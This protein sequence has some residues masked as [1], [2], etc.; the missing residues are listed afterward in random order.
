MDDFGHPQHFDQDPGEFSLPP[1]RPCNIEAEQSLLGAI[2]SNNDV[3]HEAADVVKIHHFYDPI[4]QFL[5]KLIGERITRHAIAD[6]RTLKPFID[7]EPGFAE[8][9][10][11]NYLIKL[12][13]AA[14]SVH[15]GKQYAQ[16]I[17]QLAIRRKLI[18]LY[19]E[20]A[21]SARS[22][23]VDTSAADLI[24]DAE[25][26]LYAIG[27]SGEGNIGFQS[28]VMS[29]TGAV[30]AARTAMERPTGLS[31]LSTGFI[32]IDRKL[33]GLQQADLVILAGRPGMGK[34]ALA[35]NIAYNVA[36][37]FS[38]HGDGE[39]SGGYVGMF[40]LEMP[41]SQLAARILA[42]NSEI[43]I[44]R[45]RTGDIGVKD[46]ENYTNAA[47]NLQSCPIYIDDSPAL[48]ISQLAVRARR[49]KETAGL[50]LLIVD[51]LQLVLSTDTR[52]SKVYQ[53]AEITRSLKAIAKELNIPVVALSQLSRTVEGREV[54]KPQLSDLRDSGSIEQDADIVMFVYRKEYYVEQEKPDESDEAEIVKW[55][56]KMDDVSGRAE[57]IVAKHRQGPTGTINLS[58]DAKF[59]QFGN[60]PKSGYTDP[61]EEG[62]AAS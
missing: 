48:P 12:Q 38:G 14:I 60:A 28:F 13:D 1:I 25:Q 19:S 62:R 43:P 17:Y 24:A 50:D 32:E 46:L 18:D 36:R 22:P 37:A 57:L 15:A 45:V 23:Q 31:G 5:F 47:R 58:Y 34:T 16:E 54:K 40:S 55:Q 2:L 27:E 4:H 20:L 11:V 3:F 52:E 49:L 8:L 26:K 44:S 42:A 56:K 51:Y 30:A 41:S 29:M 33:G 35:T 53:V 39:T 6:P 7:Q 21:D 61:H 9:G 59:T 10:G